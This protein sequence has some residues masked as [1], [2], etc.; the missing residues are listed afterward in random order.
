M[1]NLLI[2]DSLTCPHSSTRRQAAGREQPLNLSHYAIHF[3]LIRQ[4]DHEKL[5]ALMEANHAIREQPNSVE[6]WIAAEYPAYRRAG[7]AD[8][9]YNLGEHY[10]AR[11]ATER[12]QQR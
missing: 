6:K 2:L 7:D 11:C 8:G 1:T 3:F 4:G 5:V 10:R 9:I 12:P